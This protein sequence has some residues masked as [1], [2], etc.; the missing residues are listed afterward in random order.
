MEQGYILDTNIVIY[1]LQGRLPQ[2]TSTFLK[3]VLQAKAK[4]SV[5]TQ[6]ELLGWEEDSR[7]SVDFVSKSDIFQ[8]EGRVVESCIDIRKKY[9]IKLPDAIIAATSIVHGFKLITRNSSDFKLI[10]ELNWA[11]PF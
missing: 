1:F 11:N 9:K 5:I 3:E 4:I 8:L 6:I 2:H 7:L 10:K